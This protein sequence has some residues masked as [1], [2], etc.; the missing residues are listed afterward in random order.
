MRTQQQGPEIPSVV[1]IP[2]TAAHSTPTCIPTLPE[3][4]AQLLIARANAVSREHIARL[5][6]YNE[7]KDVAQAL[8]GM[9][10]ESRGVRVRDCQQEFGLGD[11]D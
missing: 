1:Y 11:K 4:V 8:I 5:H 6:K 2:S 7:I 9:I 3:P 10:A